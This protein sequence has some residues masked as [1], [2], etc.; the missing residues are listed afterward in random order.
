MQSGRKQDVQGI[1]KDADTI[2]I[3]SVWKVQETSWWTNTAIYISRVD[4]HNSGFK[5]MPIIIE[6]VIA[7][8]G[9]ERYQ[10]HLEL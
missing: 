6:L 7:S 2:Y 3:Y 9:K 4:T 10:S 8:K 1:S 5:Q